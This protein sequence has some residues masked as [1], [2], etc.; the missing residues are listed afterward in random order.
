MNEYR[1]TITVQYEYT[2]HAL[3]NKEAYT[4]AK[5]EFDLTHP[6]T[7]SS[8]LTSTVEYLRFAVQRMPLRKE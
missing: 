8:S 2:I 5:E 3:D 4:L 6:M 7:H 1:V